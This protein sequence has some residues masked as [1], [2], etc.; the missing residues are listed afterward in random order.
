MSAGH[1]HRR[2]LA[3]RWSPQAVPERLRGDRIAPTDCR[4]APPGV[5]AV[6]REHEHPG[7]RHG[8]ARGAARTP[9]SRVPEPP[10]LLP[11]VRAVR[12]LSRAQVELT[13]VWSTRT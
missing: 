7:R 8:S 5:G 6:L 12:G 1:V 4:A 10:S 3:L 9:P 2:D 11:K 13:R